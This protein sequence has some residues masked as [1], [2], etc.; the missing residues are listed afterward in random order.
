[1]FLVAG[2]SVAHGNSPYEWTDVSS[3]FGN[4]AFP[5]PISGIGYPP[6]WGLILALSYLTSYGLFPNLI[7]YNLVMMV[8][9]GSIN[10]LLSLLIVRIVLLQT[11]DA[12][13]SERSIKFMLF[14][15]YVIYTTA[16]W[17]Q[18]DTLPTLMMLLAVIE[19]AEDRRWHS[20]I[21][22][23]TSVA[24]K[25]IP[26]VLL[27]LAVMYEKKNGGR[28]HAIQY[29]LCVVV[30]MGFS[31]TPFVLGWSI[32][33]II[34]NWN[35][36]FVQ[37]GAFSPMSLLHLL[38]VHEGSNEL[39][40]LGLF[41]LVPLTLLYC[42]LSRRVIV[43]LPDLIFSTLALLLC[44]FL[45][46]TWVSEQNLN[47]ILPFVV[48]GAMTGKWAWKWVTMT[49]L[50]PLFFTF[51]NMSPLLMLFLVVPEPT[52]RALSPH[53]VFSGVVETARICTTA[54]WLVI[55]LAVL[56]R[57]IGG[58]SKPAMPAFV[59][60]TKHGPDLGRAAS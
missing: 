44:F 18:F 32:Q 41:W 40:Y 59:A 16:V 19:L 33:P 11:S 56:K 45:G 35:V 48:F 20:A 27:P 3:V 49:W 12:G 5:E 52:L 2:Y 22:L 47:F 43:S 8:P 53:T 60:A 36:H 54:I 38:G 46:R 23:G 34:Q 30:V 21:A 25:L 13:L 4:T 15:P 31:L 39:R 10:L 6:P 51:F 1:M 42:F 24:L 9:V 58:L 26:I 7:F 57:S 50:L 14:N 29:L 37:L 28:S 55:G 17:G